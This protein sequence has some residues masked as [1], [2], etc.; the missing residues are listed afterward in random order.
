MATTVVN[1]ASALI[2][3]HSEQ[4]RWLIPLVRED[5]VTKGTSRSIKGAIALPPNRK[6]ILLFNK[7]LQPVDQ[8]AGL[9]SD[10]F[11]SLGADYFQFSI[12]EKSWK[13]VNKTTKEYAYN[14]VKVF[15]YEDDAEEKI[16]KELKGYKTQL[17]LE[18]NVKRHLSRIDANHWKLFFEYRLKEETKKKCKQ[19]ALNRS[20]QVYTHTRSSKTLARREDEEEQ[21]REKR[22]SRGELWTTVHKKRMARI[23]MMMR[24]LLVFVK[25]H[26]GR[27]RGLGVGPYPTQLFGNATAQL[28]DFG[29]QIEE[30]HRT[31]AELKVEAAEEKAK[32]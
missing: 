17:T 7:E 1:F 20:K 10:F 23:S 19:N 11:G 12:C 9:L 24:V 30:Y 13:T 27:V 21:L 3:I 25:E 8:V 4:G 14:M 2:D 22:I 5:D 32:R 16:K 31:I 28:L 29:V 6:I 26:P 15:Q 18:K